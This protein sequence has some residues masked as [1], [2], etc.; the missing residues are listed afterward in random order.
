MLGVH[1]KPDA[2]GQPSSQHVVQ[3]LNILPLITSAVNNTSTVYDASAG[4]NL[5]SHV[6]CSISATVYSV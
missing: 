1:V 3:T 5:S 6:P 4:P 2:A